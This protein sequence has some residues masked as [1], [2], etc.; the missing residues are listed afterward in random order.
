MA[1]AA[2]HTRLPTLRPLLA[3]HNRF[4]TLAPCVQWSTDATT[5][6]H[7]TGTSNSHGKL[8]V[9]PPSDI[10]PN[11]KDWKAGYAASKGFMTGAWAAHK[12][13]APSLHSF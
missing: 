7:L 9:G 10:P 1:A 6:L 4:T 11:A 8:Y 3:C 5:S 13:L 2:A 12:D